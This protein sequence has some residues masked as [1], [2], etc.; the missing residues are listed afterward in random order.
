MR[1][2]SCKMLENN[3]YKTVLSD[4]KSV[5]HINTVAIFLNDY[6]IVILTRH[7]RESY[8][9]SLESQTTQIIL[10]LNARDYKK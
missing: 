2:R 8:R 4:N 5:Q 9:E 3:Q 7:A 1:D 6:R 10:V